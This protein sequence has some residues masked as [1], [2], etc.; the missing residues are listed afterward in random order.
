MKIN[1][2]SK[3]LSLILSLSI[4][5][6]SFTV[7]GGMA[8]NASDLV[9]AGLVNGGFDSNTDG[10]TVTAD[11]GASLTAATDSSSGT[12]T[13]GNAAKLV[14]AGKT[15]WLYQAIKLQAGTYIWEFTTDTANAGNFIIGVYNNEVF[16]KNSLIQGT[17]QSHA[18]TTD[19]AN[20]EYR[21]ANGDY[22]GPGGS[23][24][25]N[26]YTFVL[27]N[28]T[29]IYLAVRS[30]ATNNATLFADNMTLTKEVELPTELVNGNFDTDTNGWQ[31]TE[32][33]GAILTAATD[34]SNGTLTNGNAAKLVNAGKTAW[35][36]QAI[37]LQAGTYIWEFTTDTANAGNFIIGVYNNEVFDKNSL[38]QGTVQSHAK[39]TDWA[40]L[41]YR[42]GNGDYIGPGGSHRYNKYTFVLENETV[43]YLA[44][45]SNATNNATLFADNMTLN[46]VK[47]LDTTLYDFDTNGQ[48]DN[49]FVV[50]AANQSSSMKVQTV[51]SGDDN[52]KNVISLPKSN[53]TGYDKSAR[54]YKVFDGLT[55][56]NTY[57]ITFDMKF[58]DYTADK[59]SDLI[60]TTGVANT[61]KRPLKLQSGDDILTYNKNTLATICN[62][63]SKFAASTSNQY[64]I[65]ANIYNNFACI[66]WNGGKDWA[67][68]T[69][70]FVAEN[71]EYFFYIENYRKDLTDLYV[72]NI[73]FSISNETLDADLDKTAIKNKDVPSVLII[74]DSFA[75]DTFYE[76]D[77]ILNASTENKLRVGKYGKGAQ[78][79]EYFAKQIN[80]GL[81]GADFCYAEKGY[82][83]NS[84]LSTAVS[85]D[86]VKNFTDWDYV[87]IQ[88]TTIEYNETFVGY[89]VE[90]VNALIA[91]GFKKEQIYLYVPWNARQDYLDR[92][93]NFKTI[94]EQ[95]TALE[96]YI[97]AL[98]TKEDL[99]DC[100]IM[101]VHK[102]IYDL[103]KFIINIH[104]GTYGVNDGLH[105]NKIGQTAVSMALFYKFTGVDVTDNTV[106]DYSNLDFTDTKWSDNDG[107]IITQVQLDALKTIANGQ[108][109]KVDYGDANYDG[110]L[111]IIDLVCIKK[112]IVN[113]QYTIGADCKYDEILD[114]ADLT[115][116]KK[117]LLGIFDEEINSVNLEDQ[118]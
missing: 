101:S 92:N 50:S 83:G 107:G 65:A 17:V 28:E 104:R 74:G 56:G 75:G 118:L 22:M 33:S 73:Q 116:I 64:S 100:N 91:K 93:G 25:Y 2:F 23:H 26:K 10:W 94:A 96:G 54:F 84:T 30:N 80:K 98:K 55:V 44:V 115:Q 42:S 29:V 105:L 78:T 63:P 45:R 102:E 11:S 90:L 114:S 14:N 86:K 106:F 41:E 59:V 6:A 72:D 8:V 77:E 61:K 13:N 87:L 89:T 27:E 46:K 12:L 31:V 111:D 81:L 97:D 95:I 43:V 58:V 38:I 68:Y 117:W 18:K 37:K 47:T 109:P 39:T 71:D 113:R 88:T 36:Y 34:S 4:I 21:S 51:A 82:T 52:H 19:W 103:Q 76:F 108:S 112:L 5:I 32:G 24:R 1:Y 66:Y 20:L 57:E 79:P 70:K 67:T 15:A 53:G 16:D 99:K 49:S 85:F 3:A 40:N 7:L 48:F 62:L 60:A 35:L 9:D 69:M 110:S